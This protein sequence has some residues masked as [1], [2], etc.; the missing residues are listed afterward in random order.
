MSR[1]LKTLAKVGLVEL[2]EP[3]LETASEPEVVDEAKIA[4]ILAAEEARAAQTQGPR[5][6]TATQSPTGERGAIEGR[7]FEDIYTGAQVPP[8]PFAAEKL[9]KLLDGLRAMDPATRKAA[10]SAMDAADD[11]W[12]IEDAVLDAERKSRA[13]KQGA[14]RIDALAKEAEERGRADV[15]A[16]DDYVQ[17]AA[18]TIRGQIA[19]LEKLLQEELQKAADK[20]A[21]IQGDVRSAREA[22]AR[23]R[24][25][26]EQEIARL[27]EIP[28]MFAQPVTAEPKTQ[29]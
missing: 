12:A 14:E 16:L 6:S 18:D 7:K 17:K 27:Q 10:V 25:R 29:R 22:A 2:D 1:F 13:L 5:G 28:A 23:E 21:E 8:S 4:Q 24:M 20:K 11:A 9:L 15:S 26:Y 19:D 3:E